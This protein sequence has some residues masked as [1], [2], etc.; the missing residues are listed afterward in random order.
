MKNSSK[1]KY[2]G[3]VA[4]AL[5]AVAPIAAP[6]VSQ[7]ASP[8][9]AQ[10][11]MGTNAVSNGDIILINKDLTAK[12]GTSFDNAGDALSALATGG[13][14]NSTSTQPQGANLFFGEN[15]AGRGFYPS[16]EASNATYYPDETAG[17]G[18]KYSITGNG[19][20]SGSSQ[21]AVINNVK[22]AIASNKAVSYSVT[23]YIFDNQNTSG[24]IGQFT[25]TATVEPSSTSAT[26]LAGGVFNAAT[27]QSGSQT[28]GVIDDLSKVQGDVSVKDASGKAYGLQ[29][30]RDFGQ[31][32]YYAEGT[33]PSGTEITGAG[34][35]GSVATRLAGRQLVSSGKYINTG[36]FYQIL[37]LNNASSTVRTLVDNLKTA[38]RGITDDWV[39]G[40]DLYYASANGGSLYL[41]RPVLIQSDETQA[42]S[43]SFFYAAEGGTSSRVQYFNG[44]TISLNSGDTATFSREKNADGTLNATTHSVVATVTAINDLVNKNNN[45][46]VAYSTGSSTPADAD[47]LNP[48]VTNE[49]VRAAAVAAGVTFKNDT[50]LEY[51]NSKTFNIPIK[52]TNAAGLAST[53][54]VPVTTYAT[55]GQ[56]VGAPVVELKQGVSKDITVKVG[57]NFQVDSLKDGLIVYTDS[58]KTSQLADQYWEASPSS[59][60]T[61]KPGK[62][63]VVW[64]FTNPTNGAKSTYTRTVTVVASDKATFEDTTGVISIQTSKAPQYT[65]DAASDSFKV[66]DS[67]TQLKLASA[68]KYNQKATTT[69]GDVYYRVSANGYVKASDVTTAKVTP[70][71]GIVTVNN[72]NGTKTYANTTKDSGAVQSIKPDTS[73]KFF[74]VAVNPDGSRAYLVADN[75]WIPASDVVERVQAASG[76]FTVG[77]DA[78]PTFNGSGSVVK[79][80]TLKARSAWKVTGVKNINGQPYYRIATDLYVRADY[81]SYAK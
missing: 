67:Y 16:Y 22:S 74:A 73:W 53:V 76:V 35:F 58:S 54:Y 9:V 60:D 56:T 21:A 20:D 45:R 12:I 37:P 80:K 57:S 81:G 32:T 4:A 7:I 68:W 47:K 5:L 24:S 61:S 36:V 59:V 11:A 42:K 33:K 43:P 44:A 27:V 1:V 66:A 40:T 10:A 49:V 62:T 48:S 13:V 38:K 34:D 79:G 78:A 46:L 50:S 28:P 75:Q 14:L 6:V 71:F 18:F 41:V 25:F 70:Q 2:F 30:N 31:P 69:S 29:W 63:D 39:N 64:T 65:Y 8:S 15:G 55:A 19:L 26:Y 52:V 17:V 77:S 3:A 51:T 72:D 23:L